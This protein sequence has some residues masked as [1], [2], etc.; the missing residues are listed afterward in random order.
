MLFPKSRLILRKDLSPDLYLAVLHR[1]EV[2]GGCQCVRRTPAASYQGRASPRCG[3]P[4]HGQF[5]A[6]DRTLGLTSSL[7][8]AISSRCCET[9]RREKQC[10]DGRGALP[11]CES[12]ASLFFG[13]VCVFPVSN[14]ST[15]FPLSADPQK[16][17]RTWFL[18]PKVQR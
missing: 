3:D 13:S 6:A 10:L 5:I 2:V 7:L 8:L 16:D 14:Q 4:P 18:F 11:G 1:G 12:L 17:R 9:F 15:D